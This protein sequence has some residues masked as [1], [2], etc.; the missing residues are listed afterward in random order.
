ML[1]CLPCTLRKNKS[2]NPSL[3]R[4]KR[5]LYIFILY[6]PLN[7]TYKYLKGAYYYFK[8]AYSYLKWT[9]YYFSKCTA[10]FD[11]FVSSVLIQ[12]KEAVLNQS[13]LWK[14]LNHFLSYFILMWLHVTSNSLKWDWVTSCNELSS[15]LGSYCLQ[16]TFIVLQ[17]DV[18]YVSLGL[19]GVNITL[20]NMHHRDGEWNNKIFCN[21]EVL[22]IELIIYHIRLYIPHLSYSTK[23]SD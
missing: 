14:I 4:Y 18:A 5:S 12:Q 22:H 21:S 1:N 6:L 2:T 13:G 16:D 7:G 11:S 17:E 10:S 9:Y 20:R 23:S 15:A 19:L 3:E 8:S